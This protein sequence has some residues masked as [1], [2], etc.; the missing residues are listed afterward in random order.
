MAYSISLTTRFKKQ[1]K[2][3]L[4]QGLPEDEFLK[5]IKILAETGSLPD[6]YRPH[7]LKGEYKGCME[8]HIQPDWLLIWKQDDTCLTLLLVAT[9]SHSELFEKKRRK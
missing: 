4:R 3:C 5:A 7:P 8:A 9:G 6:D 1:Y 2:K